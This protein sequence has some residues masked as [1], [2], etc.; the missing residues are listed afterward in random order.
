M[1]PF[2]DAVGD[3]KLG[4]GKDIPI[5][6]RVRPKRVEA[7]SFRGNIFEL[8]VQKIDDERAD[9]CDG[10]TAASISRNHVGTPT[11]TFHVLIRYT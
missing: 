8:G 9:G 6:H 4:G 3:G 7:G 11:N 10:R 1:E 5:T 2:V